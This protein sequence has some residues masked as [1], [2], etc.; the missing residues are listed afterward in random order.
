LTPGDIAI[1]GYISEGS[2]VDSFSF[3]NLAPIDFGTEIFFTNN[4]WTGTG[5][6]GVS[7]T[8]SAGDEGLTK[9]IAT[10]NIATGTIIRSND[11][12]FTFTTSGQIQPGVSGNFSTLDFN[13]SALLSNLTLH[14]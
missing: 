4:G 9:F 3:V 5:F 7:G 11:L 8:N 10:S 13:K 6:R 12:A 2:P 14:K 1:I